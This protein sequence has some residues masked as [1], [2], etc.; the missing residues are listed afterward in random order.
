MEIDDKIRDE[1]LHYNIKREAA[2]ISTLLYA[3]LINT[4]ILQVRKYYLLVKVK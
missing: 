3:K 1:K 4:D 2:T